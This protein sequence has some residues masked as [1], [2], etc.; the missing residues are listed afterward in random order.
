MEAHDG[1]H[2][3]L[4]ECPTVSGTGTLVVDPLDPVACEVLPPWT[5][6]VPVRPA[7]RGS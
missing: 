3:T 4:C 1:T 7:A 2:R 6:L 5:A